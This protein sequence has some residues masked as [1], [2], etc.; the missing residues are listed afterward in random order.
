VGHA[1][2]GAGGVG[3]G[4]EHAGFDDPD[5]VGEYCGEYA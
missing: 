4:G 2:V 3:A 5:G 1:A